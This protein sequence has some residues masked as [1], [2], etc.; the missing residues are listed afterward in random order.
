M[1][2][3]PPLS[4]ALQATVTCP[5]C[6]Q[7]VHVQGLATT[8]LCPACQSPLQ[9]SAETWASM[10][11]LGDVLEALEGPSG[12]MRTCTMLGGVSAKTAYGRQAP[13]CSGCG[14][15]PP[16]AD[17]PAL[18]A[19]GGWSCGCGQTVRVRP[20]DDL[21][22]VVVPGARWVVGEGATA[23]STHEGRGGAQPV[24]FQCMA[25]GGALV[26]DGSTRNV[27]CTYCAGSNY[28]PDGLW[29]RL[30]PPTTVRTLYVLA[31]A[32]PSDGLS[33][34]LARQLVA[35]D[36]YELRMRAAHSAGLPADLVALLAEDDDGEVRAALAGN[37][38]IA[39]DV[40]ATLAGDS[41]DD[42]R[43]ALLANPA[44][45]QA[46]VDALAGDDDYSVR[47]AAVTS[48]RLGAERLAELAASESDSDVLEAI[49]GQELSGPVLDALAHNRRYSARRVAAGHPALPAHLQVQ[50]AGDTDSEV[51]TAL[52]GNPSL[53]PAAAQA[54]AKS[55]RSDI[56]EVAVALPAVVAA[57]RTRRNRGLMAAGVG[58]GLLVCAGGGTGLL[59]VL[60]F[61]ARWA[62]RH[63]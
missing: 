13:A 58:L 61:A 27:T 33:P 35:S 28:L 57:Q 20:A 30:H 11:S 56:A 41:D 34:E 5:S 43:A 60:A 52:L 23:D 19:A 44:A 29:L 55:D 37:P 36:D 3:V 9:L 8:A 39:P 12:S 49:A 50:L 14:T 10:F 7:P 32:N 24:H 51:L 40:L 46:A 18:V 16:L 2:A 59:G 26:V 31:D 1:A 6:H 53:V 63:L 25:C 48:G 4:L 62:F 15:A 21:A 54:L 42:V 47:V 38:D 45:P 17:V 22:Q